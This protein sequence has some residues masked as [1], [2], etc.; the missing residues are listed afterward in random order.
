MKNSVRKRT[1]GEAIMT[2]LFVPVEVWTVPIA[3]TPAKRG[4]GAAHARI[5][6]IARARRIGTGPV[7]DDGP[8][9]PPAA[10]PFIMHREAGTCDDVATFHSLSSVH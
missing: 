10:E 3:M 2:R 1:E 7:T 6:G 4:A 9:G 5:H 8:L